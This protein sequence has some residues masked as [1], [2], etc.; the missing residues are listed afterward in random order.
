[1]IKY[2]L[3]IGINE[4]KDEKIAPL[5][6]AVNDAKEIYSFCIKGTE[7]VRD[8]IEDNSPIKMEDQI[9]LLNENATKKN[10]LNSI[11]QIIEKCDREDSFI[12]YYAGHGASFPIKRI[13]KQNIDPRLI[14]DGFYKYIIPYD[15]EFDNLITTALDF[16][17]LSLSLNKIQSTKMIMLFDCCYSGAAYGRTLNLNTNQRDVSP[18][19]ITQGYTK[20]L[21]SAGD[22]RIVMTACTGRQVAIEKLSF[23]HGVFTNFIL[24][25]L[26][27]EADVHDTGSINEQDLF[28]FARAKTEQETNGQQN[29]QRN[30]EAW[31]PPLQLAHITKI[32]L[33]EEDLTDEYKRE[34]SFA[35]AGKFSRYKISEVKIANSENNAS[36]GKVAADYI[37]NTIKNNHGIA[38]S[39]GKTLIETITQLKRLNNTGIEIFPLNGSPDDEVRLTDS[40]VLTYLL[41][42]KFESET[43]VAHIIPTGIRRDFLTDESYDAIKKYADEQLENAKKSRIFLF[44]LG[45]P[46]PSNKNIKHLI[47]ESKRPAQ[48]FEDIGAVGEINFQ[49]FDRA[50]NFLALNEQLSNEGQEAVKLYNSKFFSL[51]PKDLK[52]IAELGAEIIVVAGGK[53]KREAIVAA[54]RGGFVKTLVT[55]IDT[56]IWLMDIAPV[57]SEATLQ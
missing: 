52:E 35:I 53:N 11:H 27:G 29:P 26:K 48:F 7:N 51:P 6:Y 57:L 14:D 16:E 36:I 43:T 50:G 55:D 18:V 40:M 24:T 17:V 41:W 23:G 37:E 32:R 39:C 9:I 46:K 1:M 25:G 8:G 45:I 21:T 38:V 19:N 54:I 42:S 30:G 34:I 33:K 12:F 13:S 56:A 15:A 5:K 4:Y 44:G 31:G 20:L 2:S 49:L 3:T 28:T 22:G 47:S 10:I